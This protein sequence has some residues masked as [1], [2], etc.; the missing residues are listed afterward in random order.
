[1][2]ISYGTEAKAREYMTMAAAAM[3]RPGR[4]AELIDWRAEVAAGMAAKA[5]GI[6]KADRPK[7]LYLLRAQETLRAAGRRAITTPGTSISRAGA[8][9]RLAC[10]PA[11]PT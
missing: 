2:L 3:G 8:S 10:P 11:G 5:D 6:G 7:V 4:I 9:P 1:M